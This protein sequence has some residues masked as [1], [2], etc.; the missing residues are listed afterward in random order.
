M[1]IEAT[2]PDP[3]M[4]L[5]PNRTHGRYIALKR[6]PNQKDTITSLE[7]KKTFRFDKHH[8][9]SRFVLP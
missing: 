8:P 1:R 9:F 7:N 6:V 3:R 2:Y 4:K 5:N